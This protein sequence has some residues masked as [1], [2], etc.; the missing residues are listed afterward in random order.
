VIY[1]FALRKEIAIILWTYFK[2]SDNGTRKNIGG[3]Q[4][5]TRK[6]PKFAVMSYRFV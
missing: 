4:F 5:N 3:I 2:R 1:F 6:T